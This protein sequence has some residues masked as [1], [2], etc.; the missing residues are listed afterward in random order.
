MTDK[1]KKNTSKMTDNVIIDNTRDSFAAELL[2]SVIVT[3]TIMTGMIFFKMYLA[4]IA[5]MYRLFSL[6]IV[7]VIHTFIRRS[8]IN[9]IFIITLLHIAASVA[10]YFVAINIYTLGFS[11]YMSNRDSIGRCSSVNYDLL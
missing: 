2:L 3:L 6:L 11:W 5:L 7:T 9:N 4:D 1:S 10:F 8:K